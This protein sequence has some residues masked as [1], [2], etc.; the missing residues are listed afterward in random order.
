[1]EDDGRTGRHGPSSEGLVFIAIIPILIAVV[2]IVAVR[3]RAESVDRTGDPAMAAALLERWRSAA[4]IT[5]DEAAAIA[6][7]E[8]VHAPTPPPPLSRGPLVAEVLGYVGA[9]LAAIGIAIVVAR[10]DLS[11][12]TGAILALA[13]GALLV[14]VGFAVPEHAGGPWWRFRQ[15]LHLLGTAGLTIAAGIQVGGVAEASGQAVAF[16]C[17]ATGTI[18][19]GLLYFRRDRPLQLV[20]WFAGLIA[21][22]VGATLVVS[23]AGLLTAIALLVLGGAWTSAAWRDLLP[24]RVIAL[25]LGALLLGAAAAPAAETWGEF[26]GFGVASIICAALVL[27]GYQ[28]REPTVLVAGIS[29][30]TIILSATLSF[31]E[32]PWQYGLSAAL[33][34][35][36]GTAAIREAWDGEEAETIAVQL[37]GAIT[38][39]VAA[40]NVFAHMDQDSGRAFVA[41]ALGVVIAGGLTALGALRSRPWLA[42]AGLLGILVYVPWTVGQF[43]EGRA[44]PVTLVLVGLV[45]IGVAVRSLRHRAGPPAPPLLGR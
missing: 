16:A 34:L 18:V 40:G 41:L 13:I 30:G 39:L 21:L 22:A 35:A 42:A 10:V 14:A 19:G 37:V 17:G 20:A 31:A 25:P 23:G 26:T 4:L 1:M 9:V 36:F 44:V 38:V 11:V 29:V 15:V 28:R 3:R 7:Y 24:R 27:L 2:V 45:G 8:R 6:E 43:F 33:L 12:Q 32:A 5:A